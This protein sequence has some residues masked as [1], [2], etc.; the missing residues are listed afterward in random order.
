MTWNRGS[1]Q[2]SDL[3]KPQSQSKIFKIIN[4]ITPKASL[5]I[6]QQFLLTCNLVTH[7]TFMCFVMVN[8][9]GD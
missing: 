7:L 3:D 5:L 8:N 6:F 2:S 1:L 4:H 9:H